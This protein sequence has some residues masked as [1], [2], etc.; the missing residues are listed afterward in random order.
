[1]TI[2]VIS[3]INGQENEGMRNIATHYSRVWEKE[4][5]V[6]YSGLKDIRGIVKNTVRSDV[7]VVFARAGKAI[8]Y[9]IRVLCLLSKNV[10]LV[11]VQEPDQSY[12]ALCS[13]KVP[14]NHYFYLIPEDLSDIKI[15]NECK[16]VLL[17]V[18]IDTDKF[19]PVS[20]E[21]ATRI[22][23]EYGI[24]PDKKLVIHVGHCSAGRGLDQFSKLSGNDI[25]KLVVVSGMFE[26][27]QT[28]DLL[29]G[30]GVRFQS[31]YLP[32][33]EKIYQM[34]DAYL[35]STKSSEYVISIPLSVMEA[36]ACGTPVATC[37]DLPGLKRIHAVGNAV[38]ILSDET[39]MNSEIRSLCDLKSDKGLLSGPV[40]W[41]ECASEALSAIKD[42]LK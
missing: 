28:K 27:E 10:W 29:L 21:E 34:A 37:S 19:V 20:A 33:V 12:K 30:S 3:T 42:N 17:H 36:L 38:R 32:N 11:C 1:M 15:K 26:D 24:S 39:D 31:G 14:G 2:H 35:F 41:R 25:E 40:S 4:C 22:K 18:G 13:R 16:T 8:Y 5:T 23:Q 7:T 6:L 9:L